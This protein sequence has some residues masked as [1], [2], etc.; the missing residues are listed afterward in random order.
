MTQ[1]EKEALD[2]SNKMA[3]AFNRLGQMGSS[4]TN[5]VLF[6]KDSKLLAE[7]DGLNTEL[8]EFNS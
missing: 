7:F 3:Q 2:L 8:T 1:A 5:N 4:E 6:N